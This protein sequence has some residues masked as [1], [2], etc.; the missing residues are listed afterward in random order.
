MSD[1]SLAG[2]AGATGLACEAGSAAAGG[3]ESGP[4]GAR[5]TDGR[6]VGRGT[7]DGAEIVVIH[8]HRPGR[9]TEIYRQRVLAREDG[10]IVTLQQSTPLDAPMRVNGATILEP[11]SPVIWFTFPSAWHDIGIFALADGTPTGIYANILT[12]VQF[13]G[14][15]E[16]RTTDLCLDIWL[17]HGGRA[18]LLDEDELA[19]AEAA[20]LIAGEVAAR[21]REEAARVLEEWGAG[22]WPGG[23]VG[24]DGAEAYRRYTSRRWPIVA[25][26]T[27]RVASST[28]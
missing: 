6:E 9:G 3:P 13:V 10:A 1:D 21:A 7:E 26:S 15:N 2:C 5:E 23:V 18:Q 12:P 19:A 25:T 14:P 11:S 24:C 22:R 28:A 17:P 4:V 27:V 16:W 20:G 8:Y